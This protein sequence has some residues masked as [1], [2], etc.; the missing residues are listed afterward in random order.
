M[1]A[2]L[3]GYLD[4]DTLTRWLTNDDQAKRDSVEALL[5]RAQRGEIQLGITDAALTDLVFVL[6]STR[7]YGFAADHVRA[8]IGDLVR[9]P[10]VQ[11][12]HRDVILDALDIVAERNIDFGDAMT[13]AAARLF[14]G[15]VVYSYDRDFDRITGVT[16]LEP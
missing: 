1:P 16:R 15:G 12:S 9:L 13:A 7:L 3:D 4:T 14:S 8:V 5:R 6:R 11:V 2:D 10:N